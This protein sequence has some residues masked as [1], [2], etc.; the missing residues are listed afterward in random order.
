[1]TSL[2]DLALHALC[3]V[4]L[5]ADAERAANRCERDAKT[6]PPDSAA[7]GGHALAAQLLRELSQTVSPKPLGVR[8][9]YLGAPV[10]VEGTKLAAAGALHA[11]AERETQGEAAA[12]LFYDALAAGALIA[13][14]RVRL[15]C[16]GD[17]VL[18]G[19][20]ILAAY[21]GH[22]PA[23][24]VTCGWRAAENIAGRSV[25]DALEFMAGE[26]NAALG[27]RSGGRPPARVA[28]AARR[29]SVRGAIRM[30]LDS[31]PRFVLADEVTRAADIARLAD[32]NLDA[33]VIEIGWAANGY[34]LRD[35]DVLTQTV[36][37]T[38]VVL[39]AGP[40]GPTPDAARAFPAEYVKGA[41]PA[42]VL[43]ALERTAT[44]TSDAATGAP[45]PTA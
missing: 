21:S 17:D 12:R 43:A 26:L 15:E 6:A 24:G 25:E 29:A 39:L 3:A 23:R 33:V 41:D 44:P 37:G 11:P 36:P 9:T 35:L 45:A 13:P 4:T 8:V 30:L 14:Q 31:D 40:A 18:R 27:I 28:V 2:S 7:A 38:P 42:D 10:R 16:Y 20:F 19:G 1:M 32:G 34:T 22:S 5:P